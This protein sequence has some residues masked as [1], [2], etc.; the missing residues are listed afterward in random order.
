MYLKILIPLI[1]FFL[2]I[3]TQTY[4]RSGCCSWHGGVCG[5]ACCD[6]SPLSAICGGSGYA[7][8]YYYQLVYNPPTPNFPLYDATN[9]F[10]L[11]AD[12]SITL[13][14]VI[15]DP[16]PTEYSVVVSD[17]QFADPGPYTDFRS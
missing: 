5:G 8:Q 9:D 7:P 13:D 15:D 11:D 4:A 3:P 1:L 6:G 12:G 10:F 14:F 16:N 2:F 17:I